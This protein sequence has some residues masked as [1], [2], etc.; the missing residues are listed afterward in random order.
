VDVAAVLVRLQIAAR[1][2][3][4]K[5]SMKSC[6]ASEVDFH[7]FSNLSRDALR[8]SFSASFFPTSHEA[9]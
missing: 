2:L 4:K 8:I 5:I 1:Y 3:W 9:S 6:V 7:A